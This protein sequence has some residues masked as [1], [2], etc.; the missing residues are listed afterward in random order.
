MCIICGDLEQNTQ[1]HFKSVRANLNKSE[2]TKI[3]K[4][5]KKLVNDACILGASSEVISHLE[6]QAANLR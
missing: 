3:L 2:T 5:I 4:Q 6:L 1:Q